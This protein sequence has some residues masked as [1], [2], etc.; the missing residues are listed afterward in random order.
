[1]DICLDICL[2]LSKDFCLLQPKKSWLVP[3]MKMKIS[4]D[5]D[6]RHPATNFWNWHNNNFFRFLTHWSLKLHIKK[7][8]LIKDNAVLLILFMNRV[9]RDFRIYQ[10]FFE[11]S[12]WPSFHLDKWK[13]IFVKFEFRFFSHSRNL[14]QMEQSIIHT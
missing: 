1:M 12:M 11:F 6:V 2:V 4:Y 8:V 7:Y 3:T 5:I 10:V 9:G 14:S 13:F